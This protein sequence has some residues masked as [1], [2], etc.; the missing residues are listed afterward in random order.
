MVDAAQ[1]QPGGQG[2]TGAGG[3]ALPSTSDLARLLD[4]VALRLKV[5]I[6]Y[7][8][9]SPQLKGQQV[10]LRTGGGPTAE[11][12]DAELWAITSRLL[13]QR[14][15]TTVRSAGGGPS[16]T[17][18]KLEDAA[19]LAR[20]EP[21]VAASSATA[22]RGGTEVGREPVAGFRNQPVRLEHVSLKEA[23]EALRIVQRG[24]GAA[25]AGGGGGAAATASSSGDLLLL[26]DTS[27]RIEEQLGVLRQ[28]D[29]AENA[30]VV[31][32]VPVAN[33]APTQLAAAVAQLATKREL[34]SG[35]K[36]PG[37]VLPGGGGGGG[38][39]VIAPQRVQARWR[40]LIALADQ[41]EP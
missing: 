14:G 40:E 37:E 39:T 9:A 21:V 10:T 12:S 17:V 35:E 32:V 36:L 15:L 25:G 27:P 2:E 4:L 26:S 41:R 38:V 34:V 30:T 1:V 23:N 29:V 13:V 7:D 5:Q 20:F 16:L 11:V 28:L 31:Q 22:G 33:V 24:P 19:R 3:V 18:V 8:P 6:D